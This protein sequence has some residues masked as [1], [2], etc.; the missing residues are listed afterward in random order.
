M[1]KLT[2]F[3]AC[4]AMLA[5]PLMA[6]S[7]ERPNFVF[8]GAEDISPDLGCYGNRFVHTPNLDR[9]AT[10]GARFERCFTHAPVCA[11]SRS[12]MITGRYPT[13]FGTHH[14]RSKL[15]VAPPP[16]YTS[17]LQKAGYHVAWPGKTD[18]NFD[19][20]PG[21][22]TTRQNWM[23]QGGPGKLPQ[24]FFAYINLN[25]T[26]ES[27][28]RA[29][30]EEYAKLT[31]QLTPEQRVDPA[32]VELPPFYPDAP[33][34][35]R[36]LANY[37]ELI[38]A[39]DYQVGDVL[40]AIDEAGLK[41]NT[42]VLF[43]GDHGRGLPR[44]KRWVYDSGS[45]CPLIMRWPGKIAPGTVRDDLVAVVDFAPTFL[46]IAGAPL[47]KEL[48]GR[49]FLTA[50]G[51]PG[52]ER[53]RYVYTARDRMD[54]TPDRIRS[55]RDERYR[56]VRNFQ[57]E[58]PYAQRVQYAEMMPTMR[59]WRQWN[60]EGKLRGPQKLF[61]APTKPEE[62]LY[63]TQADH[64]E[65]NNLAGSPAPE[66][67]E[68]LKELRLALDAWMQETNDLGAVPEADL[69]KRGIVEDVTSKYEDRKAPPAGGE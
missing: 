44:H 59:V 3:L 49:A 68:K 37:Y 11:P 62:E 39:M 33:E 17:L 21:A 34:V 7:A 12:G 32:K 5:C 54:E 52:S 67:Q 23:Q 14:M 1:P 40:K 19:V 36:D 8:I 35:R 45:R 50:E 43:W 63:D 55:V 47:P 22:F 69:V 64:H 13:S 53:R 42:V 20:P 26:H 25:G 38:T 30:P 2:T 28:V 27:K 56:Y 15:K 31:S 9:L 29:A 58:L 4:F 24:P 46:T 61:F 16:T 48:D 60:S 41:E 10:E 51:K 6:R 66:H 57:P 65:V 18:F